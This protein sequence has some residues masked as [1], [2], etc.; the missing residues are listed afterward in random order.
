M[1]DERNS[2]QI[3]WV[4]ACAKGAVCPRDAAFRRAAAKPHEKPAAASSSH[5]QRRDQSHLAK[6]YRIAGKEL[7]L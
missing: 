3:F 1:Y 7:Q 2:P 5:I 6:L 4:R